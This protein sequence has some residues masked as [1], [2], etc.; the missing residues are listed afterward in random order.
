MTTRSLVKD[1][2][3]SSMG[4]W[5]VVAADAGKCSRLTCTMLSYGELKSGS[6]AESHMTN[7]RPL[8]V[9]EFSRWLESKEEEKKTREKYLL[10]VIRRRIIHLIYA[11]VVRNLH[12]KHCSDENLRTRNYSVHLHFARCTEQFCIVCPSA[13]SCWRIRRTEIPLCCPQCLKGKRETQI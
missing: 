4:G 12:V 8:C 11:T 6:P 1:G 9:L 5:V 10:L 2:G 13:K 3:G 7:V